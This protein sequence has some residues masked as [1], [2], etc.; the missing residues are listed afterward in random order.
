MGLLLKYLA[1]KDKGALTRDPVSPV[2]P[3]VHPGEESLSDSESPSMDEAPNQLVIFNAL[4]SNFQECV[5]VPHQ[6]HESVVSS[7]V[8]FAG[9][10]HLLRLRRSI[11]VVSLA[12][13]DIATENWTLLQ[14]GQKLYGAT[15]K[16]LIRGMPQR[17]WAGASRRWD[18]Q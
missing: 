9:S 13:T 17:Q 11:S 4:A 6:R 1:G 15:L 14:E 10:G 8:D 12:M 2:S 5:W 18:N 3:M 7:L 16:A